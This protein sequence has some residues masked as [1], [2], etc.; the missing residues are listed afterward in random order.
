[1]KRAF[2]SILFILFMISLCYPQEILWEKT[3]GGNKSEY[4]YDIKPTPDFGF[5]L[6][7]S[8]LSDKSGN[9]ADEKQGDLDYFIWK[10][11]ENGNEEWQRSFGGSG[12][13]HLY[14]INLTHEGGYILGGSSNSPKSG[15]KRDENLG[16]DDFWVIKLNPTG[17]EE[18][19]FTL[20]GKGM[21]ILLSIQQTQ[22]R[23][24]ILG[25]TS[26]SSKGSNVE[27]YLYQKA[28][29][30]RGSMDFWVV[31]ISEQ[32]ELEW[33]KTIG[34][35]YYDVL[36]SIYQTEDG[37]YILGGYSNSIASGEKS[38]KNL[39]EGDY[40]IVKLN[41][42]GTIEWERTIGGDKDDELFAL[43]P[44]EDNGFLLGG[45]SNSRISNLKQ[46]DNSQG[47]DWWIVRTDEQGEIQWQKTY[48]IAQNDMLV[49]ITKTQDGDFLLSGYA[50]AEKYN[51]QA[52]REGIEDYVV[53]K[54][55][56]QGKELWRKF[57]GGKGS[58]RLET[59]IKSRDGGYILAGTSDSGADRDKGAKNQGRDDYWIV[60]LLDKDTE[61]QTDVQ[62]LE[63]YPNP[64]EDYVNVL[65]HEDFKET[66]LQ[67]FD[68]MGA[69]VL[70]QKIKNKITP[71]DI[72][73]LQTGAYLI[74]V[75][76]ENNMFN[77]KFLKR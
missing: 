38:E 76:T 24:F 29:D 70:K 45:S 61:L 1:M 7:G 51:E 40:W 74:K 50:K 42:A 68:M 65:I 60:K 3:L 32:G 17:D 2:T 54:I 18:W 9:K 47:A 57:M 69:L 36:R 14:C 72:R 48:D 41:P 34:G 43:I 71:V 31:K 49:D 62:R 46:V 59:T 16:L 8:S 35:R 23:G 10:M 25:G 77:A 5:I 26:D 58:D 20:G 55:D 30:S 4:L 15:D 13:D 11:D 52:E 19:Q 44:T 63:I 64:A 56:N 27:D 67:I 73:Q 21:D 12:A 6:A 53:I 75:V 28:E 37:G 39:G 22:D 33:Q 66:D